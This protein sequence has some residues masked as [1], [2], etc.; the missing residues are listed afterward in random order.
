MVF[1]NNSIFAAVLIIKTCGHDIWL[2][3]KGF[4]NFGFWFLKILASAGILLT[5]IQMYT[6]YLFAYV[7]LVWEVI[8]QAM[9]IAVE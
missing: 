3:V 9:R 4:I 7:A 5:G 1:K 2:Q 8:M 6:H